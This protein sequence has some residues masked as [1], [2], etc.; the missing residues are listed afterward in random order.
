MP[1]H[2]AGDAGAIAW[3]NGVDAAVA[4]KLDTA[5]ADTAVAVIVGNPASATSVSLSSTYGPR[6]VVAGSSPLQASN[7]GRFVGVTAGGPP[8]AGTYAAGD[9]SMDQ[10]GATWVCLKP[11]APGNWTRPGADVFNPLA[12]SVG[13]GRAGDAGVC[14]AGVV[15]SAAAALKDRMYGLRYPIPAG[16]TLT[17]VK[18]HVSTAGEAGSVIRVGVYKD[19]NGWPGHLI[20]DGGTAAADSIGWKTVTLPTPVSGGRFV[21]ITLTAQNAPT[22]APFTTRLSVY[23]HK[24]V[25]TTFLDDATYCFTFHD[26]VTG[27][28]PAEYPDVSRGG[29][30]TSFMPYILAWH[31]LDAATALIPDRAPVLQA[32][33]V[34]EQNCVMEPSVYWDGA[35]WVM[36][37][38]GGWAAEQLGWATAPSIDGPWAKQGPLGFGSGRSSVFQD[39]GTLYVYYNDTGNNLMV[40]S[41]PDIQSLGAAS[42]AFTA[43]GSV[44]RIV[45]TSVI[46]DAGTYKMMFEAYAGGPP[47]AM[48]Y[49]TA[50]NPLGP[51]TTNTFPL[52]TL[53]ITGRGNGASG[54]SLT[55]VG[56]VFNL[57]YHNPTLPTDIYHATSSDC[58][59][60][61]AETLPRIRRTHPFEFDQVADSCYVADPATSIGYL[62]WSAMDN[63]TPAA[64]IMRS[65]PQA[66]TIAP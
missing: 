21:S 28:L 43:S 55:K 38:S 66:M 37:Y 35:R 57:W 34:W 63:V 14:P 40:K 6:A 8:S 39:A 45:N 2:V 15:T 1:V 12:L 65:V 26:G 16:Q 22:T 60:W 51:F 32:D 64:A 48:G 18:F 17:G 23:P 46:N 59:T 61:T 5:A 3:A 50:S 19:A 27:A 53:I 49:A 24:P 7:A 31:G 47:W 9:W 62:F 42:T 33:Q 58:V 10:S 36:V 20:I 41:G 54:P 52:P 56:A 13:N 11:G 44:T 29:N 30:V 25:Q 4:G